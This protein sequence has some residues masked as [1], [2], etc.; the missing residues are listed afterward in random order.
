[1]FGTKLSAHSIRRK[2]GNLSNTD[3]AAYLRDFLPDDVKERG[4]FEKLNVNPESD[5]VRL[6]T[7]E[8]RNLSAY[9]LIGD[10]LKPVGRFIHLSDFTCF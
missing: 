8:R 7:R 6:E 2:S 5:Q 10:H 3:E 9:C 1:M 4:R